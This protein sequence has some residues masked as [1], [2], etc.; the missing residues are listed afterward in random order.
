LT[1]RRS[2]IGVS[3]DTA[4][5]Y[6]K[7]YHV[8]VNTIGIQFS[9]YG[10]AFLGVDNSSLERIATLT[11]GILYIV[12]NSDDLEKVYSEIVSNPTSCPVPVDMSLLLLIIALVLLLTDW[13]LGN[14]IYKIIP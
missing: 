4:I 8:V 13:L 7:T 5:L 3:E 1:D 12:S 10:D 2:N 14:T 11:G 6:A 9:G